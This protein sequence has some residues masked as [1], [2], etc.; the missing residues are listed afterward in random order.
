VIVVPSV[1][2]AFRDRRSR[3][4]AGFRELYAP[5]RVS[6][7]LCGLRSRPRSSGEPFRFAVLGDAEP[8]RFWVAR[9]LFNTPGVFERQ[10]RSIEREGV[11]FCVQL[12]DMVSRGSRRNYERFFA[13]LARWRLSFPYLPVIGNHDRRYP[14]GRSDCAVFREAFGKTD[15][16]FDR[17]A[18]RFVVL[19]TSARSLSRPQFRWLDRVLRADR[20][21]CVFT[22]FPPA[23]LNRWT[24]LGPARGI[25]GL[26]RD[27]RALT[28]LFQRRGVHRVYVG[29]IHAFGVQD[30]L[31]VRYILTGG[32]GS[33][34][35]PN[36]IEDRYHHYVVA[37]VGPDGISD[38]LRCADGRSLPIPR[39]PVLLSR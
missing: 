16:A 28:E 34:L 13:D 8:G 2:Q 24:G 6:R 30:Y 32:G 27:G 14:H 38:T 4:A 5:W 39:S 1:L 7:Q 19:D 10:L 11:D 37:C 22:H 9:R 23:P 29:H 3:R 25:V 12:G 35:Y 33:P 20:L 17:G 36:W 21:K 15:Y 26:R 31:G 18:A